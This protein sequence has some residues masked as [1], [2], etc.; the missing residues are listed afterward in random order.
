MAS[1]ERGYGDFVDAPRPRD[2]AAGALAAGHGDVPGRPGLGRRLATSSPLRG[3]CCARQLERLAERGWSTNAATELEFLVFRDTYEEAWRKG[4]REL[5]PANL[6]NVDYSLLGTAR[7]EPLIRRIR[8]EMEAAGLAVENSKGECN[9]G[10][11]EINFRYAD[12]LRRADE[13]VDLQ[14]RGQGDRRPGGDGD[15]LHGEVQ[16]A[17][18]E[19]VPHPLLARRRR[20][21]RCSQRDRA[22]FESLP[23]RPARLP[24]RADAAAGA[25][26][27]LLQA[28]RR[29][30][31]S[32]RPPSPG[33]TTTAPARCGSSGT[34]RR[35]GSRTGPAAR[36]S[37][38][39]WRSRAIIAAGLHG[40]EPGSSSSPRTRATPTWPPTSRGCPRR[41]ATRATCSPPARWPARR[42]ATRSS[43]TTSTPP[44]S[45][46][47][48]S[49][50]RSPT[51]SACA[52]SS[53][54]ES[55][56]GRLARVGR[57]A[58]DGVRAGALADRV[59]GDRRAARHR[60]PARACC[61]PGPACRPSASC[62]PSS[63]IARST[64]RQALVALGQ[65][66]HLRATRGRGGGTFVADPQP[67]ARPPSPSCSPPG[68]RSA[69]SGWRSR[70][71]SRCSPPSAREP[72]AARR[73]R[74]ARR[75]ARR[76][77]RG[78]RRLPRRPT[79]AC[80]SASP[81]RPAARG[82]SRR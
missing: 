54:C 29:R 3:R 46:W 17:R 42:S 71:G 21:R 23:R 82:W 56:R 22:V 73:A 67:P 1:W 39:T 58:G 72:R 12:A 74:G 69:T 40:V 9:L 6:Y 51:G 63:G 19:L 36:T 48:R 4:Y 20:R 65:S 66:G 41:C 64:L 79:S 27:Q 28:L 34:G 26:R 47:R 38:R 25:E 77:A 78:L 55:R 7:V 59:R 13:H 60:D 24:A 15:H 16:R 49:S 37:T 52:A 5:E 35:C 10:Q 11:H 70:S 76:H 33:R 62:A 81:R 31:R 50:R 18:G 57:L 75:G 53:G 2:A 8:N 61:R 44:T 30:D 80:T 32:P 43:T 45:S 14:E 68:A